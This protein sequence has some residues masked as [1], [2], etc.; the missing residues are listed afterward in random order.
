M[1]Y[2]AFISNIILAEFR[3]K[4][5]MCNQEIRLITLFFISLLP[6]NEVMRQV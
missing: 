3:D 5:K 4:C 2:K 6:K 1:T